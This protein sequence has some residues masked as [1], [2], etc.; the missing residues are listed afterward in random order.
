MSKASF[1]E[2]FFLLACRGPMKAINEQELDQ[3]VEALNRLKGYELTK[4]LYNE[5]RLQL[6]FSK[7][8]N[9]YWLSIHLKPGAPYAFLGGPDTPLI[10]GLKKPLVQFMGSHILHQDLLE[11]KRKH[12]L[13]RLLELEFSQGRFLRLTLFPGGQN[14]EAESIGK[15]V[16]ATK[17]KAMTPMRGNIHKDFCRAPQVFIDEWKLSFEGVAAQKEEDPK[18]ILVKNIAKKKRGLKSMEE[19]LDQ[20]KNSPWQKVGQW[21]KQNQDLDVPPEWRKLVDKR[22][23]LAWNIENC[24]KQHKKSKSKIEGTKER[25]EVLIQEITDLESGKIKKLEPKKEGLMSQASSK[26]RTFVLDDQ[27]TLYVG[28]SAKDNQQLLR[29]AKPWFLWF[30]VQDSPGAYAILQR[31]RKERIPSDEFLRSAALK[32]LETSVRGLEP[33]RWPVI[34][35]ECR[36]VRPIKGGKPGQVTYSNEKLV[37]VKVG[38]H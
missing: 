28:K 9:F 35:A 30:H 36:Y 19:S 10:Q 12:V 32:L 15:K 7:D 21:L 23:S 37:V 29:K 25:I 5:K 17:P 14:I 33:G 6:S 1:Q 34:I 2:A 3:L 11:V 22:R 26:G 24:F 20:L 38:E 8:K 13:G 16:F 31:P 27:H 18:K 4:V